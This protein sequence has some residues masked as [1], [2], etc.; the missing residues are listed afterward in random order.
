MIALID[1]CV[2]IDALQSREPFSSDAQKI[3]LYVSSN[4]FI[5]YITSN[6]ST[7]IYYLIHKSTHSNKTSHDVLCKIFTLFK[8]A[9]TSDEDC[10]NAVL[11]KTIDY[12]D[13]LMIEAAKRINA[14]CIVTRSIK[15]FTNSPI[16][17]LS[18][19]EFIKKIES[20]IY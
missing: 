15:D 9:D 14:D 19:S 10:Q 20:N 11:S 3:F 17:I 12:E 16:T 18:P 7:D 13:A 8:I 2:I 5:G 6:S 4:K 1:T